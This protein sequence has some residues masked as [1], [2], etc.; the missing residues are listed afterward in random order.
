MIFLTDKEYMMIDRYRKENMED[1]CYQDY[2]SFM[3][4]AEL[5]KTWSEAKEQYLWKMFNENLILRKEIVVEKTVEQ[6][7]KQYVNSTSEYG[8]AARDFFDKLYTAIHLDENTNLPYDFLYQINIP[9]NACKNKVLT[10]RSAVY[11]PEN[12]NGFIGRKFI[13]G[14]NKETV[15]VQKGMKFT[16]LMSKLAQ[17]Y[18][19]NNEYEK[20]RIQHSQVLN[21]KYIKGTL[22][23]SIHPLDYMTMSDNANGWRSCMSW[24]N[25]GC[26][27]LGTVEMMNS[28]NVVVAYLE[29]DRAE[30]ELAYGN[31]IDEQLTWN[32]KKWRELFVVTP[33]IIT[34]VKGY[35]YHNGSLEKICAAW[36]CN[37]AVE[38]GI[39]TYSTYEPYVACPHYT[40]NIKPENRQLRVARFTTN[41]MYN[42][43]N[44]D[45]Y[46]EIDHYAYF[47][48]E[49][50]EDKICYSG[51]NQCMWCGAVLERHNHEGSLACRECSER[52]FYCTCCDE[53]FYD[54]EEEVVLD[55]GVSVCSSCY[56]SSSVII[57]VNEKTLLRK[58]NNIEVCLIYGDSLVNDIA[59]DTDHDHLIYV[60]YEVAENPELWNKFFKIP[61][62]RRDK[63]NQPYFY[64]DDL[65]NPLRINTYF[66]NY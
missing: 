26:F 55:D 53:E 34:G 36:L 25:E 4:S 31:S 50:K 60:D 14:F 45:G 65:V 35:P 5:L 23:L 20:Y 30:F 54:V 66:S 22:C 59:W 6:I 56:D 16:T 47:G 8:C 63:Y 38:A 24:Q 13:C 7:K 9:D 3:P 1:Q 51:K 48:P 19:L 58:R 42:D 64:R 40:A 52:M 43:F 28:T 39:G 15:A 21:D 57:T 41:N 29:S 12:A 10:V 61:A 17:V 33:D 62:F 18:G 2:R 32:S 11:N 27:R 49:Y 46:N 37:L 44:T